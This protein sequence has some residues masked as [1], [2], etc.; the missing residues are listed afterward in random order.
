MG[1]A[2]S[3]AKE[4]FPASWKR[5]AYNKQSGEIVGSFAGGATIH[6]A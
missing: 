1:S 3:L 6:R 5:P 2:K 4:K